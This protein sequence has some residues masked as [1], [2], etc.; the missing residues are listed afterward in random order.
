MDA[1]GLSGLSPACAPWQCWDARLQEAALDKAAQELPAGALLVSYAPQLPQRCS[2][3]QPEDELPR[4]DG[5]AVGG[6]SP[7]QP[8]ELLAKLELPVSWLSD[9]SFCVARKVAPG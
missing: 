1:V 7:A 4:A 3:T 8:F 9:Q 6:G 5:A 2:G